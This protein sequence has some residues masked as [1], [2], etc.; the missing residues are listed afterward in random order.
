M[1]QPGLLGLSDH[2]NRLSAFGD[3]L[4][5]LARIVDFEVFRRALVAAL[6]DG[7]GA[8]GGRSPYDPVEMLKVLILGPRTTSAMRG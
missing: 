8:N 3:P 7:D 2:L 4:E 5:E 1:R 6:A